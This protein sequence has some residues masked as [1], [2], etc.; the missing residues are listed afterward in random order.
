MLSGSKKVDESVEDFLYRRRSYVKQV[1]RRTT[2]LASEI[3]IKK[4]WR[5]FGHCLRNERLP[6]LR[7]MMRF[8]DSEWWREQRLVPEAFK[9]RHR[10]SGQ[11]I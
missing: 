9:Q 11:Q 8:R 4:Q 10:Q 6:Q 7:A 3:A 2:G 5:Y 1:L